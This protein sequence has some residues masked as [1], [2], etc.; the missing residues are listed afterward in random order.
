MIIGAYIQ[1]QVYYYLYMCHVIDTLLHTDNSTMTTNPRVDSYYARAY[2]KR[3]CPRNSIMNA[4]PL[5]RLCKFFATGII[6]NFRLCSRNECK[7]YV[8][9]RLSYLQGGL[10]GIW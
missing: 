8:C 4:D 1:L 5:R 2:I 3:A 10:G 7:F 6:Y 9:S